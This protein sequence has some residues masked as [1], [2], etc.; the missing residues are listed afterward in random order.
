MRNFLL[1]LDI[2]VEGY[3]YLFCGS[4]EIWVMASLATVLKWQEDGEVFGSVLTEVSGEET[5]LAVEILKLA[6]GN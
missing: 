1:T 3:I 5:Q 4:T 6:L 2:P